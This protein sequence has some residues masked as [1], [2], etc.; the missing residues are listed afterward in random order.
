MRQKVVCFGE[1]L[2]DVFPDKKLIGGAP[3]NVALRLSSLGNEVRMISKIGQDQEAQDLL[4][5]L[6]EEK[7][8]INGIQIDPELSTGNVQVHLDDNNSATYTI[9]EHVAWDYIKVKKNDIEH[10]KHSDAFI[11]G[12]LSCRNQVSHD[13]LNEFI[14]YASFKI[15][16]ANLRAPFYDLY[17]IK[18][19]MEQADM[20][21]LNDQELSEVC[22]FLEWSDQSIE[23]QITALAK[24]FKSSYVCITLG[25][26]GAILY[27]KDKFYS[28]PG[29]PIKVKDTVGAGDSFLAGLTHQLLRGSTSQYALDFGCAMGA[30]VA[31]SQGANPKVSKMDLNRFIQTD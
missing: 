13:T 6:K 15:F 8:S 11:Y 9:S 7:L 3:L 21:K 18:S 25:S 24:L 31:A 27:D 29:Y 22:R 16:D 30:I 28:N 20:I 17:S 23:Q 12:S 14:K 5:Y 4:Q 1:T 2:W 26:K 10:I 19:L